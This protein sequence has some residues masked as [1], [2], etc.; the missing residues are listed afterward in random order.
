[1]QKNKQRTALRR[2]RRWCIFSRFVREKS[3]HICSL[4]L[5]AILTRALISL[6]LRGIRIRVRS[7]CFDV[8][9]G[10]YGC[11]ITFCSFPNFADLVR[12]FFPLCVILLRLLYF[13]EIK[14]VF[15]FLF[16]VHKLCFIWCWTSL[17]VDCIFFPFFFFSSWMMR[18]LI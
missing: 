7:S 5:Y 17:F 12:F 18:I 11:R 8:Y 15:F 2:L 6:I 4:R 16:G 10:M 3:N 13:F 9:R 14:E 1:M